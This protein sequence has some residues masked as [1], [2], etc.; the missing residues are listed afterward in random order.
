M[1]SRRMNRNE[2][3]IRPATKHQTIDVECAIPYFI[4]DKGKWIGVDR[5]PRQLIRQD[6]APRKR[7]NFRTEEGGRMH[8]A[9]W[10]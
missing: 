10:A 2:V 5:K 3:T 1:S 9:V 8:M 6:C 4:F 7:V